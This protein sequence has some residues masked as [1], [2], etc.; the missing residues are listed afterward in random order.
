MRKHVEAKLKQNPRSK[1]GM[2]TKLNSR[3]FVRR[4]GTR[5]VFQILAKRYEVREKEEGHRDVLL[6]K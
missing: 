4:T 5:V 3:L 6:M 2:I 1:L